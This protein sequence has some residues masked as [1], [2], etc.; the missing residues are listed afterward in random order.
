M[1][2]KASSSRAFS[3]VMTGIRPTSS[4]IRPYFTRSW[5]VT[6]FIQSIWS[7][8]FLPWTSPPKPREPEAVLRLDDLLQAVEGAA[9]D[10]Q[11]VGGVDLDEL[12]LGMLAPALGRHVGHRA[13]QDFQQRLLHA[14]AADVPGDGR[15]SQIFRAILSISSI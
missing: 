1:R 5:G 4:G 12:L 13:L 11:D 10:K 2:T 7:S 3:A 9:A 8:S 6:S 15:C 14:L